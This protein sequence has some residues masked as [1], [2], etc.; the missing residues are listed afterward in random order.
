MYGNNLLISCP[1]QEIFT[2]YYFMQTQGRRMEI[3]M[4]FFD[5]YV[6]NTLAGSGNQY[7]FINEDDKKINKGR[8]YYKVF[9]GGKFK[10][11][12]LFSNILDS[13]FSDGS[14]S[15][16]NL[17]CND[18]YITALNIGVCAKIENPQRLS[19]VTFG[20]SATKHVMPGEFF[21]TDEIEIEAK[22]GDYICLEISFKGKM[23]PYHEEI[24]IPTF[25]FENNEWISSK[26]MPVPGMV[27]CARNAKQIGFLGDSIT[28]GIGTE[29]NSY[30]HWNA[31]LAEL[32]GDKFAYWNLGLGFGRA[33]DAA[34]D[35]AWLYKAKQNDIVFVCFGVNDILQRYTAKQI[36]ENLKK[37]TLL[38]KKQG[39]RVLVQTIPPFDYNDKQIDIWNSVNRFIKNELSQ[40]ADWI[41]DNVPILRKNADE[42]HMAKFGGHPNAEGCESW[43]NALH[44]YIK[45]E[46]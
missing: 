6:S 16:K 35:G 31:K 21:C 20:G 39:I 24:I 13:T 36:K 11:S 34:S 18:W 8:V 28:Q 5:I 27:G 17:I 4:N 9:F 43:A 44:T 42:P 26:Y 30:E 7:F 37:I 14:K 38:L 40:Y 22:K 33:D 46:L 32:L 29:M 19:A 10:Y 25:V 15:H 45:E 1:A 12:F 2:L 3:N 23:I 41:F